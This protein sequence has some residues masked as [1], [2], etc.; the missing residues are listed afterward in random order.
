MLILVAGK[1]KFLGKQASN[2]LKDFHINLS[3]TLEVS[4]D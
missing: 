2:L 1:D 3:W 4:M